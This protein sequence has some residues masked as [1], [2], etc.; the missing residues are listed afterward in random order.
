MD[1]ANDGRDAVRNDGRKHPYATT[2]A[3]DRACKVTAR[4][5]AGA[6]STMLGRTISRRACA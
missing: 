2:M 6:A 4:R 5:I 1:A 3:A